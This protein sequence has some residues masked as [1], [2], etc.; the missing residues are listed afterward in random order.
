MIRKNER[1]RGVRWVLAACAAGAAAAVVLT[2]A[3]PSSKA[4]APEAAKPAAAKP[5]GAKA[6]G[7]KISLG[8]GKHRYEWVVGWAK[9]PAGMTFGN[10]H[11]GIVVDSQGRIY[12]NTDTENAII[13]FD[14][15]GKFLKSWGKDFKGGTHGMAIAKEG[16]REIL[17]LGHIGRNEVVKATLEGEVL[18][19]Y[20]YPDKAAIYKDAK[21]YKPTGVA[22]APNGDF[23]AT[24]GYGR[25]WVHHYSAQGE[26]IRSFGG[27]GKDPGRLQEPHGIW[28]D[29]RGKTPLVVVADRR[30]SRLQWFDLE[31]KFVSEVKDVA[32]RPSGIHQRGTD[33]VI[34]DIDAK[35]TIID[36]DN[37]V[38]AHMGE[39][40][41]PEQKGKNPIRSDLWKDGTFIAPHSVR[42]DDEGN[43][44]V[45]DWNIEGRVT[46]LKRVR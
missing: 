33:L 12:V 37:K 29:T 24:D 26:Y 6:G 35:V 39:N 19:T 32:Y 36:K 2:L 27:P 28:I 31:G 34:A 22:V 4:A 23:Y 25:W 3:A 30:N 46:K 21:E 44:Y 20:P 10:T 45:M 42:W 38:V 41:N 17:Y 1:V 40:T 18:A 9:L 16:G 15:N 5:A 7:G 8:A 43:L 14:K 11:G 13:V